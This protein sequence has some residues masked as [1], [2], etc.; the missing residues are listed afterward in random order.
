VYLFTVDIIRST[1]FPVCV[2]IQSR[3]VREIH[4]EV[5]SRLSN[6]IISIVFFSCYIQTILHIDERSNGRRNHYNAF[7]LSN[8]K[9]NKVSIKGLPASKLP[10]NAVWIFVDLR[11]YFAY[12]S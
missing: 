2:S 12:S 5:R 8:S 4:Y 7:I 1:I 6:N 3:Q 11:G 10:T 9:G